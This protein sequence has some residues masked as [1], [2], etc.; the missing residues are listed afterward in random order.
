[1]TE[2]LFVD[3]ESSVLASLRRAFRGFENYEY[4]FANSPM[5]AL[6]ILAQH[7]ITVLVSDHKMPQM[8]GAEF[9]A[10][11]K[12]KRPDT[13]RML[14]TG[15]A[16]LE[17]VQRAVNGGEIFR[18]FL[19]PWKDDELRAAVKQAAEFH[20]LSFENKRLLSLT[21]KQ[22]E[23]LSALNATLEDQVQ[24]RT[25]QLADALYTARALNEQLTQGLYDSTKALVTMIQLARPDLGSHSR[26]VAGHATAIGQSLGLHGNDLN[27]LE[28]A[29]LLHD[30]GKLGLPPFI[31]EKHVSDYRREER[32]LYQT[33]PIMGTEY[34]KGVKQY[35]Q[36]CTF[37]LAHHEHFDG[38]GF[39]AGLL[40]SHVPLEAY[41]IGIAD[42]FDH[43]MN[44]PRHNAEFNYQYACQTIS[45]LSEKEFPSRVVQALLDYAPRVADRLQSAEEV[46]LGLSDLTPNLVLARDV[47]TMSGS[48]LL[49]AGATLTIQGIARLRSIARLD[50]VAGEI[51]ISRKARRES[52][53]P[54]RV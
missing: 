44:R 27:D 33:H 51:F 40:G 11:V 31:V 9:L 4:H 19:K 34:L 42:A 24:T 10:R 13:I 15:Q 36:I 21:R 17:A 32:D 7:T 53:S 38:G 26:R 46:R 8:A 54:Q 45:E 52:K 48:L 1:M 50:P 23:D 43:L 37:I 30:G 22:N 16:D 35:E 49:A 47:Y 29:A 5:E 3:D 2:V 39:P 6:E 28:I 12:E 14:L 41:I 25:T 20:D 18:F